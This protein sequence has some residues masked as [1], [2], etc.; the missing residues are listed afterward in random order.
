[1]TGLSRP[2][3]AIISRSSENGV[4]VGLDAAELGLCATGELVAQAPTPAAAVPRPT[5]VALLLLTAIAAQSQPFEAVPIDFRHQASKTPHKHLI[6]AMGAGVALLDYDG[7][8][9]LDIFFVNGAA[10][11]AGSIGE[12]HPNRLYRNNGDWTFTDVT[13]QAGLAGGGYGMGAAVGDFDGD[14]DPDLYVSNYGEDLLYRN[15]DG[16]FV[17]IA[18]DVGVATPGWS[19][20]AAF[21]DYDGD[22]RLDLFVARYLEWGFDNSRP[23]G[24]QDASYCHPRLFKAVTHRLYRNRG[25]RFEDV[26]D[27][28]GLA[29]TPGKGLGVAVAD[30]DGDGRLDVFV[31]NDSFPQQLFVNRQDGFVESAVPAGVAYDADGRTYAG[32]GTALADYDNDGLLDIFANALALEGYQIYRQTEPGRFDPI[33]AQSGLLSATRMSSGWGAGFGDFDNDGWVDLFV[34][35]SHVMDDI[36]ASQPNL[37]YEESLLLLRNLFGRFY[38]VS[39][40]AGAAFQALRAHRGAAIGDLDNDGRLDVVVSVNDGPAVL[41][42]NVAPEENH[43]IGFDLD[44]GARALVTDS[45]GKTRLRSAGPSGSYLSSSDPRAHFGLGA[46][47]VERAEIMRPDGAVTTLRN[48]PMNQYHRVTKPPVN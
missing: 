20:G 1:M 30:L 17:E 12:K 32:M 41:L 5:L 34:A 9:F 26:S 28:I 21:L 22:G 2:G 48:P 7:D 18:K 24:D 31:A 19:A 39:A 46:A 47:T 44:I 4:E 10:L 8:G 11:G 6:E 23:C 25:D 29:E 15:D 3:D 42:R 13:E 40:K 37:R 36:E 33:A 35:Q 45:D 43:W 38:N 27:K 16:V 14:G